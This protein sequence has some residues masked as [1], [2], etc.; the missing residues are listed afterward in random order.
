MASPRAAWVYKNPSCS[1][2][3]PNTPTWGVRIRSLIL[4]STLMLTSLLWADAQTKKAAQGPPT[5][6]DR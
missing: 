6:S 2:S 4:G 1:P 5:N 3:A